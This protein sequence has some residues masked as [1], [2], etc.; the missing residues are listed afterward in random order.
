MIENRRSI[1]NV[2]PKMNQ[3][4]YKQLVIA[5]VITTVGGANV[6]AADTCQ[7]GGSRYSAGG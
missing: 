6:G 2:A 3:K 4:L 1:N 5:M 7:Y